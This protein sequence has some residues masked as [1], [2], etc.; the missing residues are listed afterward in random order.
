MCNLGNSKYIP[1]SSESQPD[2]SLSETGTETPKWLVINIPGNNISAG[3][4]LFNYTPP[5][6]QRLK[7]GI[8]LD[9]DVSDP[10][11]CQQN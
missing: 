11:T 1:F 7:Q 10:L 3:K 2:T 6:R 8:I 5:I 4:S 9:M